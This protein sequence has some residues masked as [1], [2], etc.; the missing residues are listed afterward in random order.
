MTARRQKK[1]K[2]MRGSHTHGWGSKKKHRGAGNRGGRGMAGTGKRAD[3]KKPSILVEYGNTYFGKPKGFNT[4]WNKKDRIIN[5][6][7]I[8]KNIDEYTTKGLIIKENNVYIVDIK[9]LGFDKLLGK[10]KLK[11]K[12]KAIG[13]VSRIAAERIK[14]AGGEVQE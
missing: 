14:E 11:N 13:K 6:E 12:Y 3:Q 5:L 1:N 8:E 7:D 9:K 4:P 10:G 2:K